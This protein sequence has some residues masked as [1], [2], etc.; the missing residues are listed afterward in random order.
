MMYVFN[1]TYESAQ[2]IPVVIRKWLIDRYNKQK[3]KENKG[4]DTQ[5]DVNQPLSPREREKYKKKNK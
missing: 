3:E 5:P 4:K 1:E 2:K